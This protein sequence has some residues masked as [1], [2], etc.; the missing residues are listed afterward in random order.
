MNCL[1]LVLRPKQTKLVTQM[2][3][4]FYNTDVNALSERPRPRFPVL[5]K[6][7]FAA[8]GGDLRKYG[9]QLGQLSPDDILLMYE[10]GVGIVGVGR[11]REHWDGVTHTDSKYYTNS[12]MTHLD[13]GAF[14]Y[15][16]CV[17]WFLDLSNSQIGLDELR[18]RFGYKH[19]TTVTRGTIDKIVKQRIVVARMIEEILES[20]SF[21]PGEINRPALYIEGSSQQ[22][23]VNAYERSHAAVLQCKSVHGT[24][25]VICGFDFGA[26]YGAEFAGFI[27]VHHLT[28]LSEISGEYVVDPIHDLRPV[29]PNCH[30]VIHHGGRL[31]SIEEV[32][33]L[34]AQ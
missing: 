20:H 18:Q 9:Q 27:H 21:F 19:N 32:R 10:N 29:C 1:K 17:E 5:I 3:Y 15:R 26:V 7:G 12:E 6:Q 30:A 24:T 2:N 34:L 25:C 13:G 28:P 33:K 23:S 31:R 11:V 22:I 4:Y 14:E 8:V 16:I